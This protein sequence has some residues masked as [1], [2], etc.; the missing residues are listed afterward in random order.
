MK[1]FNQRQG[2]LVSA[3]LHLTILMMLW[4]VEPSKKAVPIEPSDQERK[5]VLL[6]PAE[7]R[8]MLPQPTPRPQVRPTPPP[9]APTPPPQ[10]AKDRI[11][12][13]PPTE[14][15]TKRPMILRREDDLTK[16]PKGTPQQPN[17]GIPLEA[18]SSARFG[19]PHQVQLGVGSR[20]EKGV[21]AC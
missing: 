9:P 12:V 20:F 13:G 7:I 4:D 5:V 21:T 6:S 19:G 10:S 3:I 15:R 8:R 1:R 17:A 18:P 14:D 11:S 2:F 16:V